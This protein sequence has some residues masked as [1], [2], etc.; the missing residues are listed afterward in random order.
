MTEFVNLHQQNGMLMGIVM[1]IKIM[2]KILGYVYL[3]YRD[4]HKNPKKR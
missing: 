2:V 1:E 4:I 3:F